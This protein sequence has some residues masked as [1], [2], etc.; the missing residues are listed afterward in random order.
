MSKSKF[1]FKMTFNV[2]LLILLLALFLGIGMANNNFFKPDY[3]INVMLKNIV[4]LGMIAL[5]VTLI[6]ITGGI[7]LSVGSI[8]VLCAV[9]GGTLAEATG[10]SVIALVGVA[11]VGMLCGLFNGFIVAKLKISPLVT[12]LATMYLFMGLARGFTLGQSISSFG[13]ATFMGNFV[14]AGVPVQIILYA[15]LA[16]V[17]ALLLS[18]TY[19]GR[20]LYAIGLSENAAKFAGID[21]DRSKMIIY[22]LSGI[23][24]ALASVIMLG[25]F[26]SMKYTGG[27]GMNL[28]VVTIAVL[29]G[30]NINGGIGDMKG[31]II[32]TLIIAVLNSGLTVLNIPIDVQTIV[33]GSVLLLSLIVYSIIYERAKLT[34]FTAHA[35][36]T[37][38]E[39]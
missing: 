31:T 1:K 11:V 23:V 37:A 14:V 21:T 35:A 9:A 13:A 17:F 4:E 34:K 3:L 36:E 19:F 6:I 29:G 7:D 38:A 18:K 28:K 5:P 33:Q 22:T 30:A 16:V 39:A 26:T 12:T 25:R 32:A 15:L 27:D 8:V 10:S 24:C 20:Y 2:A